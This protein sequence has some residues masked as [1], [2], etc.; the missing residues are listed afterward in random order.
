[1]INP[2]KGTT[3][4]CSNFCLWLTTSNVP[5]NIPAGNLNVTRSFTYHNNFFVN[6]KVCSRLWEHANISGR[7]Y[8]DETFLIRAQ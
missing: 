8:A 1:M 2:L 4:K 6:I 5:I 3:K 7:K